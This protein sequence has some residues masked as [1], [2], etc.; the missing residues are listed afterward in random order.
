MSLAPPPWSEHIGPNGHVYYYNAAT[1]ESTYVHPALSFAPS[2]QRQSTQESLK[3]IPL[4][5]TSVPGTDW[6]RIKTTQGNVFYSHKET[7]QSAWTVPEEIKDALEHLEQTERRT[8]EQLMLEKAQ[9]KK[10]KSDL[11]STVTDLAKRKA[12]ELVLMDEIV[13]T[14]RARTDADVS[15][16]DEDASE[17]ENEEE[18]QSEAA[19]QGEAEPEEERRKVDEQHPKEAA[20]SRQEQLADIKQHVPSKEHTSTI[21]PEKVELSSEEA[22]ALFKTLLR[23]K[24]VNPLLPWDKSLPLFVSDPR[25]VLLPSVAARR[26]AFDEYCRERA[27]E[28]KQLN[29]K[30]EKETL[31]PK[32]EFDRLLAEEVKSTRTS[33]TDF[34][35]TWKKDRRFYGW[36]R[37]ERERERRFRAFLKDLSGKKRTAAEKVE[38]DFLSLLK[39]RV[40]KPEEG[41]VWK[42]VKRGLYSDPRYDA[43]GSSSLREELFN[44]FVKGKTKRIS[45]RTLITE[46][47]NAL[48]K[49]D[50]QNDDEKRSRK[51]RALKEREEK[52]RAERSL[53]DLQIE[54]SKQGM[55]KEEGER[56]FRTL[57]TDAIRDPQ[58]W[59]AALPQLKIDPR[60][61]N[62]SLTLNH[63]VQLFNV[64]VAHLRAKHINNLHM[65]FQSHAPSL[66]TSFAELPI[67]SLLSSLPSTKLGLAITDLQHEYSKWQRERA[68]ECRRGFDEMLVENSF[69]EFWGRLGKMGGE[70]VDGGVKADD[71]GEGE[72]EGGGGPV[73]MKALARNVD[74]HDMVKVVKNDKRYTMF[75]HTPEQR[76]QWFR[77][78]I[79]R[80]T[81]PKLSV[82][83][84][85]NVPS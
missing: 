14:K 29:I 85:E 64:H 30:K 2:S 9:M 43:V 10:S 32:E 23:E 72:G 17:D 49:F 20:M 67:P 81:A 65:L 50:E 69:V 68:Q 61:A 77:D 37:D 19:E 25:Y 12:E 84:S 80:L 76:E 55:G 54:R 6:L 38:A 71:L 59:D 1:R 57:L 73:D 4:Y 26:D 21:I 28:L 27:R 58:S 56:L 41:L 8:Q 33:W 83:V 31:S 63:Q 24:D 82:H 42:D 45:E 22:K 34:R 53:L 52:V 39:E 3:E 7:K 16:D 15:D 75:D 74:I 48:P 78:Y 60:F 79:G 51:D 62:S 70:G 47:E 35:R 44:T 11:E 5:K 40:K 36:G 46:E 18:L 13:I 66:A